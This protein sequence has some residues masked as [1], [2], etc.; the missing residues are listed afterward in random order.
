IYT[1]FADSPNDPEF[2]NRQLTLFK[3]ILE[4]MHD[5]GINPG[6]R[7]AANSGAAIKF[8]DTHLDMIRS[9]IALY[10]LPPVLSKH[11]FIPALTLEAMVVEKHRLRKGESVSYGRTFTADK[12][13][14]IATIALG[15]ADGYFRYLSNKYCLTKDSYRLKQI[16]TVCMDA[17]MVDC[18]GIGLEVGDYVEVFGK[19]KTA[20]ELAEAAGTI[21]YE[22]LTSL[23][24]RVNRIYT[25]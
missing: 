9:G 17:L 22:V 11:R 16:G 8:E 25:G 15:Y 3:N 6:I 14:E 18:S 23:S 1:H 4:K 20:E 5:A 12:D 2:T 10:G 24:S 7:H 21:T 13:M 19:E